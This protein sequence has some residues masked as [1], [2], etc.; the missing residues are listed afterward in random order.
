MCDLNHCKPVII[1]NIFERKF[2]FYKKILKDL[3]IDNFII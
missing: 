2:K 1:K 3:K